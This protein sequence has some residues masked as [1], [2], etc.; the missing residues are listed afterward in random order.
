V[1]AVI[2]TPLSS[3]P[4]AASTIANGA[5]VAGRAGVAIVEG[6][7]SSA[8]AQWVA[9]QA[10]A[11]TGRAPSHVILTHY[12]G[13]HSAGLLGYRPS[14]P[15]YVTTAETAARLQAGQMPGGAAMAGAELVSPGKPATLDLS[16]RRIIITPRAGHTQS[17]LEVTVEEPHVLVGGDLLWNR[18]FPNYMDATPSVL[19]REVRAMSGEFGVIRIPAHGPIFAGDDLTRYVGVLDAVEDAARKARTAG[20]P[21]G[22]AAKAFRLPASLGEWTL[23]SSEYF[24]VPLR[25]WERE[26]ASARLA[27]LG[28]DLF[29][30]EAELGRRPLRRVLAEVDDRDPTRRRERLAPR[31]RRLRQRDAGPGSRISETGIGGLP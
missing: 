26:L 30:C 2:S 17:D 23:F 27:H 5:I 25:A 18:L 24:A 12:H 29:R 11:L 8:G 16:G 20:T 15:T 21:A 9:E 3:G 6:F 4:P 13:D 31:A 19:S 1:W 28:L 7:G 14:A 10:R 22:E